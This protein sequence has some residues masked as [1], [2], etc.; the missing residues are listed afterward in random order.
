METLLII[1][2]II[3]GF[4]VC[5]FLAFLGFMYIVGVYNTYDKPSDKELIHLFFLWEY[6]LIAV[7]WEFIK[8]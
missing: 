7:A 3:F 6:A 4:H 8:D 1:I 2:A 5:G